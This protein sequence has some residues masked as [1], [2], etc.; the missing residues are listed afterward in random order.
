[1]HPWRKRQ[2][3]WFIFA[4]TKPCQE[5]VKFSL[6]TTI[7]V[8]LG[9]RCRNRR[10]FEGCEGFL[11]G[12]F[13]TCPKSFCATFVYKFSPAM[14]MKIFFWCNLQKRSS[15]DFLQT[16]GAISWSQT[17]LGVVFPD[18]RRSANIFRDFCPDFQRFSTNQNF[19]GALAPLHP[20]LLHHSTSNSS[21]HAK[22]HAHVSAAFR[23]AASRAWASD[24]IWTWARSAFDLPRSSCV[25]FSSRLLSSVAS[26]NRSVRSLTCRK[27]SL[28]SGVV[29]CWGVGQEIDLIYLEKSSYPGSF[30]P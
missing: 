26:S 9:H 29:R 7:A 4:E 2:R 21:N 17:P 18:V 25:T 13:Q 30:P 3:G 22:K 1:L 10:I 15:C 27:R 16:L 28:T 14:I 19:S 24:S 11:P 6:T 5:T 20:R 23:D 12:F 8:S